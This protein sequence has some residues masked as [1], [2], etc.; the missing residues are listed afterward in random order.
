MQHTQQ[1]SIKSETPVGLMKPTEEH[2]SLMVK[3]HIMLSG[4][5][6]KVRNITLIIPDILLPVFRSLQ[7]TVLKR[8]MSLI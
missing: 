8:D 2:T 4:Q 1:S 6:L 7:K 5:P 3:K